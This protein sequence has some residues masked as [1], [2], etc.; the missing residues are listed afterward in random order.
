MARLNDITKDITAYAE[1]MSRV[2]TLPT[3]LRAA[4]G[5]R[6]VWR[7]H[8]LYAAIKVGAQIKTELCVSSDTKVV[9]RCNFDRRRLEANS[10]FLVAGLRLLQGVSEKPEECEFKPLTGAQLNGEFEL[11]MGTVD[12]LQSLPLSKFI[13]TDLGN[14]GYYRLDAPFM[15]IPQTE[16]IPTITFSKAGDANLCVRLEFDGVMLR[17]K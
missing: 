11:K 12:V 16:I 1:A 9:G 10:Y 13:S 5:N 4:L 6:I 8:T 7:D 15:I 3:A 14:P 17:K 2:E